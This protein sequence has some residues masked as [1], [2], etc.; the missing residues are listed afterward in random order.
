MKMKTKRKLSFVHIPKA[1]GLSLHKSLEEFFGVNATLRV[2]NESDRKAFLKMHAQD[3]SSFDF[4]SGHISVK[5]LLVKGITFPIV[6]IVRDPMERLISIQNYLTTSSHEDHL[7]FDFSDNEEFCKY[8]STRNQYNMQ[9]WHLSGMQ[10]SEQAI[11]FIKNNNVYVATLSNYDEALKDI[12]LFLGAELN[13]FHINKTR[14]VKQRDRFL[15]AQY[16]E[17]ISED[18]VLYDYVLAH[19]HKIRSRFL[20]GKTTY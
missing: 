17:F 9:C 7:G 16:L 4:I 10:N 8:L 13:Q 18:M 11:E 14:Y 19:R 5:E 12:S 1:A 6:S 3:L 2:G 20:S 15:D